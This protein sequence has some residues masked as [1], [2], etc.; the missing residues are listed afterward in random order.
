MATNTNNQLLPVRSYV[1]ELLTILPT[2]YQVERQ[3]GRAFQPLQVLDGVE[4]NKTA[5]SVKTNDTEVV[6]GE[7]DTTAD[8]NAGASRFGNM[9]EIVYANTDVKYDVPLKTNLMLDKTTVNNDF[10]FAV[11]QQLVKTGVAYTRQM[12]VADGKFLSESAQKT[13]ELTDLGDND[14]ITKM[15]NDLSSYFV[16]LEVAVDVTMYVKPELYNALVDHPLATT[17]KNSTVSIDEN[18]IYWFKGF[19]IEQ[20]PGRYFQ[21]GDVAYLSADGVGIPFIGIVES[22]TMMSI[23][24]TGVALQTLSKGGRFMLDDNKKAVA[25]VTFESVGG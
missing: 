11:N 20:V 3:F 12:N 13:I 21:E 15:L 22:R 25:K 16:D 19:R 6:I 4:E 5:F 24:F 1:K 8:V 17:G 10:D 23:D 18:G 7:Y 14:Q 9:Q 2:V